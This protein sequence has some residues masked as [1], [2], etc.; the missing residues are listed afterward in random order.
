MRIIIV[1]KGDS[2]SK[3]AQKAY[4]DK[5]AYDRIFKA[6]PEIIKNPNQIFV[7]QKIRIPL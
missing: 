2:L 6:N 4:G 1:K 3:L 7:G 5:L